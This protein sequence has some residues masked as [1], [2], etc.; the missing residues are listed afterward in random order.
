MEKLRQLLR[1]GD[2]LRAFG[3]DLER[4]ATSNLIPTFLVDSLSS[5]EEF[6][7]S[8][9]LGFLNTYPPSDIGQ[10]KLSL[11]I[12]RIDRGENVPWSS[13][14]AEDPWIAWHVA[15]AFLNSLPSPL[16][17]KSALEKLTNAR[18]AAGY[19]HTNLLLHR[20]IV[21]SLPR[22]NCALL[23]YI[24]S[25]I[26]HFSEAFQCSNDRTREIFH[27]TCNAVF[28]LGDQEQG[29][30]SFLTFISL[31]DKVFRAKFHPLANSLTVPPEISLAQIAEMTPQ[32]A[33]SCSFG[34]EKK[35]DS[36]GSA[37]SNP[38]KL[39][40]LA[41][42][43]GGMRGLI[44]IKI[45]SQ[46]ATK[47]YGDCEENGTRKLLANFDII[48]GTSTGGIIALALQKMSLSKVREFYLS[49]GRQIFK[50]SYLYGI[51]RWLRYYQSGDYYSGQT[52]TS[53]FK[54]EFGDTRLSEIFGESSSSR[55]RLFLAATNATNAVWEPFVLR[56]Y[57][58][59]TSIIPGAANV[60]TPD[61][62]RA[63]SAAPTYFAAVQLQVEL[64]N[65]EHMQKAASNDGKVQL[66][67]GGMTANNPTE[68]AIFEAHHLSDSQVGLIVSVGTGMP[69]KQPGSVNVFKML[70]ELIDICTSSNA[71]HMRVLE[72]IEM[73]PDPKPAYFRFNPSNG[74][75]SYALDESDDTVLAAL[76]A[77]TEAYMKEPD[78]VQM[79]S[80]LQLAI[81]QLGN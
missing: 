30:E 3:R 51:G 74:E 35:I 57:A 10:N 43:G 53:L 39:S 66:V 26:Q 78:V 61:A 33:S 80:E 65:T 25:Q 62:L 67:D 69:G 19:K 2:D 11:L 60:T 23:E 38:K 52:L 72:W 24:T 48:A 14:T 9:G 81:Q 75:G 79:I 29:W 46:L 56:S 59:P 17:P 7:K 63:T 64:Q 27:N 70:N 58:N 32:V 36:A 37:G 49:M 55:Q 73:M 22:T 54:T 34:L 77:S 1:F 4:H 16:L 76:E 68:L 40:I 28:Q 47:L 71:I 50:S 6:Y 5:F 20:H 41:L 12:G 42:D 31:H 44:E 18:R 8:K 15:N 13:L 21:E 45:L